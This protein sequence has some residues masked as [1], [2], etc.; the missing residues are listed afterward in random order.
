MMNGMSHQWSGGA[1]PIG[2]PG[3]ENASEMI[4]KFFKEQLGL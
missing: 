3:Y 2:A 1:A 4:W